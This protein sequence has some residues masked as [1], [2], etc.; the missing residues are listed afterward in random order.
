[1]VR[2]NILVIAFLLV[3]I[4]TVRAQQ[5]NT[6]FFMHSVPQSNFM[7][8]AVQAE[9]RWFIGLPVIS[10]VHVNLANNGFTVN[11]ILESQDEGVYTFNADNLVN[12]LARTNYLSSEVY[13][14]LL[15][16]GHKRKD[17]YFT[18]SIRER[19]DFI[20]FYPR[21]LFAFAYRGNTQF[22]G[23]WISL[24]G[25]GGQFNHFREYA[26]G[27]SKKVDDYRTYGIR[28]KLLFGKL[29]LNTRRSTIGLYTQENTFDLI[30]LNDININ[31]S[32]PVSLEIDDRGYYTI[33]DQYYTT[34]SD[35][36]LN[37]RN[38]GIAFDAGFISE[39][40][41]KITFSGSI[42]DV[43]AIFYRSNL[44]NY[45]VEGEF[46]YDG[47]LGDTIETESYF[48]DIINTFTESSIISRNSYIYFL[49]PRILIGATYRMNDRINFGGL[50]TGKIYRQKVQSGL[51]LSANTRFARYF[52]ASLSWSYLHRS[53]NNLGA[54]LAVG[55]MPIQFYIISDNF[56][57]MIWPQSTK[58]LNLRFGMNIIFGCY[59]KEKIS[60][61]G[62]YWIQQAEEK[63][64]RKYKL[65]NK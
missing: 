55:R 33:T 56:L 54:G 38:I 13:T 7:N 63:R 4:H 31:G 2:S 44:T 48:N 10:S 20:A 47:P 35:I 25:T 17:Y 58:N 51:M 53:F 59:R 40:D 23:E 21:D 19:D 62:C 1:M 43:G 39:F 14:H 32:L 41:E 50:I 26:L 60:G 49:Q 45:N 46:F 22:E 9:C 18:L 36:I 11:Q 12:K 29:N 37:R 30:F 57:G 6:L 42:L 16:I 15:A 5:S 27:V 8:P 3:S 61:C 28:G 34:I 24:D 52:A 64:E 65:M